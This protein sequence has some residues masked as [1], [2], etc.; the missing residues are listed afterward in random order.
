MDLLYLLV[1][2]LAVALLGLFQKISPTMN[3]PKF[4]TIEGGEGSGKSS[5]WQ[6]MKAEFGDQVLFTREPGGSPYGEAIRETTLKN[7]LAATA[8]AETTLC[9]MFAARFDHLVNLVRPALASGK[10]VVSDRFDASSYAYNVHAQSGGLVSRL[11]WQLRRQLMI[12]PDL[13]VYID[14][15][16]EEGMRRAQKRNQAGSSSGHYDHFDDRAVAFHQKVHEGYEKFFG[17]RR[18]LT[19]RLLVPMVRI[20]ANR[21]FAEVKAD[22][23][24]LMKEQL[25]L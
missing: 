12:L 8:P 2:F 25:G 10:S 4:I 9:L 20:D 18:W 14:V 24:A 16:P 7:P 19:R 3:K 23:M 15:E 6:A 22:F 21:P 13:Y 11:F 1:L 17:R 5:L